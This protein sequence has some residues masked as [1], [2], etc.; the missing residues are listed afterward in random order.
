MIVDTD[1]R[2]VSF[3][4]KTLRLSAHLFGVVEYLSAHPG[5]I[6]SR[7]QIMHAAFEGGGRNNDMRAVDTVIKRLRRVGITQVRSYYGGGY[8][9]DDGVPMVSDGARR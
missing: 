3:G 4:D 2:T 1:C 5:M 8:Y 9:W 7:D 6:R